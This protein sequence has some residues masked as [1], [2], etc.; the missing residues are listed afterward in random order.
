MLV[1]AGR[2]SHV[3][4][5]ADLSRL[6]ED[7][8]RA[9]ARVAAGA[10][11]ARPRA[12]ARRLERGRRDAAP[13]GRAEP[14]RERRRG[15]RR[16]GAG[17]ITI[18]TGTQ[19]AD[20]ACLSARSRGA[21]RIAPGTYAYVEVSDDGP[22]IDAA[23]QRRIFDPFFTTQLRRPRARAR[24]GARHRARPRRRRAARERARA[25]AAASGC[26]C[27]APASRS[28][29]PRPRTRAGVRPR[30]ARSARV[31]LVDDEPAVLEVAAEFL[32]RE[33][34]D[35]VA[36]GSGREGA[37]A[38]RRGARTLRR[39]GRRP[40]DARRLG[41]ARRRRAPRAAPRAAR[42]C[43]RAAS[44]P[45][46][47]AARCLE[48]GD[49]RF[50]R[51]PYAPDDLVRAVRG[52]LGETPARRSCSRPLSTLRALGAIGFDGW[53]KASAACRGRHPPR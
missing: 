28:Q 31:L 33:G 46:L 5:P 16:R 49:A 9:A 30:T 6:V 13:P 7:M 27:P 17:R 43:S 23:T 25:R 44:A 37:R 32:A 34:F 24:G 29:R 14:R 20:A 45:E 1:Y 21:G 35:V 10:L 19:R 4:K 36:A 18:R 50:L 41:R 53:S 8:L 39:R 51:K 40:H 52:V 22:G 48:L 15:A 38:L 12:R 26:C 11:R 42:S 3:R 2:G 47:A